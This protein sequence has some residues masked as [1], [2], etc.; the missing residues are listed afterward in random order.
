MTN[1]P[2]LGHVICY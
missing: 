2:F 1:D